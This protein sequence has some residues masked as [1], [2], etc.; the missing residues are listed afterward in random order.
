[1]H[2]NIQKFITCVSLILCTRF[3]EL[4]TAVWQCNV[5]KR[6]KEHLQALPVSALSVVVVRLHAGAVAP[7]YKQQKY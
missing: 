7:A 3:C 4:N 1:M 6:R 5:N 2:K